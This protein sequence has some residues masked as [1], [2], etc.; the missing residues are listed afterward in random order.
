MFLWDFWVVV[1]VGL[2][3]VME[4]FVGCRLRGVEKWEWREYVLVWVDW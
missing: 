2:N 3:V 1:L 4:W